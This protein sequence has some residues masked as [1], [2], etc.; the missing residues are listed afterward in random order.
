MCICYIQML[1]SS[2]Q[3]LGRVRGGKSVSPLVLRST[4]LATGWRTCDLLHLSIVKA[5]SSNSMAVRTQ[6]PS[7]SVMRLEHYVMLLVTCKSGSR[8]HTLTSKAALLL[9][10]DVDC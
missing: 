9:E 6:L 3:R 1:M 5:V 2:H 10:R 7:S 4:S 8:S